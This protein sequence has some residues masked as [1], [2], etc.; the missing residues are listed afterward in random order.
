MKIQS[1]Y[2]LVFI[3]S[4]ATSCNTYTKYESELITKALSIK[5]LPVPR[6]KIIEV[7]GLEKKESRVK[8]SQKISRNLKPSL[9]LKSS[10]E[11]WNLKNG[12]H[13]TADANQELTISSESKMKEKEFMKSVTGRD[14]FILEFDPILSFKSFKIVN[15]KG[16]QIHH[17]NNQTK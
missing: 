12:Y 5:E 7:F 10:T 2:L 1:Q 8:I 14:F 4:I 11:N 6:N 9:N 15:S 3:A 16:Y 17:S 13:L